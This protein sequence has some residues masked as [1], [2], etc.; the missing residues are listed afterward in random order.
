[1]RY[2]S[3]LFIGILA[4]VLIL[5]GCAKAECKKD[6]QCSK[7]HYAG[8]CTDKK[9]VYEPIPNECGNGQCEA[10]VGENKCTCG[11]DCG[12]CTG[13]AGK[14]LV[15]QCNA[16]DECVED[17]PAT[18][19]KPITQTRELAT[20]GSK[21]SVTSTFNQPFNI[22][23]DRL[24]LEFKMSVLAPSMSDVMISR[25]ELT[26]MTTDK[27]TVSLTDKTVDKSLFAE[28]SK[29]KE[30]VIIDF[31]GTEKDGELTS[32]NLKI[33]ADYVQTSGTTV[34]PKS[35]TLNHA[36]Q[37]LKFA[38]ARPEKSPGCP[39]S[40]DD[41]N[42]GTQD[43]CDASTS[44]FC[45]NKPI[46]G[47][48]GNGI[49]DGTENPC[50]CV[51]DCGPCSGGGTYLTRS[52]VSNACLAQLKP[53]VTA[54]PQSLFDD[55]DMSA[56]HMQNSYKYNKPFNTNADKFTLEFT[57]YEKQDT[58]SSVKIKDIRLLAGTQEIAY[59]TAGK[60]LSS[61]GQKET[62]ELSVPAQ[63]TPEVE[64]NLNLR[65][66]YEYVQ[67]STTKQGD[68]SKGLGKVTLLSPDV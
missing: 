39:A 17:I 57:L 44:Y 65:V 33:Y 9:C 22:K 26:G 23:K 14:Y 25:L 7:P 2:K 61:V 12:E 19:Q 37:S 68:Y 38:Y 1:M 49:C 16:Q 20:G 66:W 41:A 46:A 47:A 45:E 28:G 8:T 43:V 60:T 62:V 18:T 56:F 63:A 48:C 5:A 58:V 13:K 30:Y 32:L 11:A 67:D 3:L 50:T 31:P 64:R 54:Q 24:E 40:C 55:R 29:F 53:G 52:C 34:T 35:T 10:P 42:P 27:R 51:Q 6:A 4:A 21:I 15:Q 59:I 36:Y